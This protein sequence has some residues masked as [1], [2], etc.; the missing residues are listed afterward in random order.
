M[1]GPYSGNRVASMTPGATQI[2]QGLLDNVG[3]TN[4][5]FANATATM[6]GAQNY[7]SNPITAGQIATTDLKPYMDPYTGA[8]TNAAMNQ[9]DLGNQQALTGIGDQ[10]NK[11]RAF[12]GSRQGVAE[13]AMNATN[14]MNKASLLANANEKNFLQAREAAT[15]DISRRFD[16]DK[17]NEANRATA[18]QL[19]MSGATGEG[20]LATQGQNAFLSGSSAALAGQ[21]QLQ[22]QAQKKIDADKAYYDEQRMDPIDRIRMRMSALQNSPY[23]TKTESV[24]PGPTTNPMSSILGGA[25]SIIGMA[26]TVLPLLGMSD[27]RTK[28]DITKLGK[29]KDTGLNLYAYRYKGDP[30]SYP[31]VVGPMAQEVEKKFPGSTVKVGSEGRLAI[32][33]GFGGGG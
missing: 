33:L 24:T 31:K 3:S 6:R 22:Q 25:S 21:D 23:G 1:A 19:R 17:L 9:F 7:S 29:D 5:A 28:T 32:N 30:K 12:G 15:G 13:G 4:P 2:A 18:E 8:V 16:A 27:R 26:G 14:I 11:A 20:A 10:A